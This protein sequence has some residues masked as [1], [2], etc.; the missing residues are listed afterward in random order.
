MDPCPWVEFRGFGNLNG[1]KITF[2]VTSNRHAA[3]PLEMVMGS[4]EVSAAPATVTRRTRIFILYLLS[5]LCAAL[6]KYCVYMS[7]LWNNGRCSAC[8]WISSFHTPVKR[9]M[10]SSIKYRF[11][12]LAARISYRGRHMPA[13]LTLFWEGFTRLP[14]VAEVPNI[15]EN[16]VN[17][18][19]SGGAA[20]PKQINISPRWW[21]AAR[22][23]PSSYRNPRRG[24]T[25][26][27]RFLSCIWNEA[28]RGGERSR[29]SLAG[30]DLNEHR[31]PKPPGLCG[32][33]EYRV[34]KAS[35]LCWAL[36]VQEWISD[37][38][39]GR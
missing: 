23:T 6:L 8:H 19:V 25:P 3:F 4:T 34:W 17:C 36:G 9:H 22:D 39:H 28:W 24:L 13:Y 32:S 30:R 16:P 7:V 1:E 31:T 15:V 27:R 10:C 33:K 38:L 37:S 35:L 5:Q 18:T 12:W 11:C 29:R 21:M 2:S 20:K 14:K 26:L